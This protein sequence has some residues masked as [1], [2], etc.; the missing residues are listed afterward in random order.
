[1]SVLPPVPPTVEWI[2]WGVAT[3][4]PDA[5]GLTALT[6]AALFGTDTFR[7][8]HRCSGITRHTGPAGVLPDQRLA[9]VDLGA[10]RR[11][12]VAE[13]AHRLG[14]RGWLVRRALHR[15][16]WGEACVDALPG[17]AAAAA[18]TDRQIVEHARAVEEFLASGVGLVTS[19]DTLTW[20]GGLYYGARDNHRVAMGVQMPWPSEPSD[21]ESALIAATYLGRVGAP[22]RL[23]QVLAQRQVPYYAAAATPAVEHGVPCLS[24]GLSTVADHA[25]GLLEAVRD[26]LRCLR[27]S[28]I[29][30]QELHRLRA[31]AEL[32]E[33][34]HPSSGPFD[35]RAEDPA[36]PVQPAVPAVAVIGRLPEETVARVREAV[37]EW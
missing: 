28:G 11:T 37:R 31:G 7:V 29:P 35:R 27:R 8:G 16:A 13:R 32:Y 21:G 9:D 20:R 17:E 36:G 6:C 2:P 24:I 3:E 5:P 22:G 33:A 34:V 30:S 26:M 10:L 23:V 25:V 14:D 18:I 4:P 12:L 15:V 19:S 1:M